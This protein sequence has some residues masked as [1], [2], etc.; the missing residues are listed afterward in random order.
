MQFFRSIFPEEPD[1]DE[2]NRAMFIILLSMMMAAGPIWM[3]SPA[4]VRAWW[5]KG[6]SRGKE[7]GKDEASTQEEGE[8]EGEDEVEA[9][10]DKST[11]VPLGPGPTVEQPTVANNYK[12]VPGT[13]VDHEGS[14]Q[15]SSLDDFGKR[16]SKYTEQDVA[17]MKASWKKCVDGRLA[18]AVAHKELISQL[19]VDLINTR[20]TERRRAAAEAGRADAADVRA[21]ATDARAAVSQAQADTAERK[22][23]EVRSQIASSAYFK[24]NPDDKKIIAQLLSERSLLQ[25]QVNAC[26]ESRRRSLLPGELEE[27][28][29]QLERAKCEASSARKS[30]LAE[31]RMNRNVLLR[32]EKAEKIIHEH[33]TSASIRCDLKQARATISEQDSVIELQRVALLQH[34]KNNVELQEGVEKAVEAIKSYKNV[35]SE[36]NRTITRQVAELTLCKEKVEESQ[37]RENERIS[38]KQQLQEKYD[39]LL[40]QFQMKE[41]LV[42]ISGKALSRC[43]QLAGKPIPTIETLDIEELKSD[44]KIKDATIHELKVWLEEARVAMCSMLHIPSGEITVP[45]ITNSRPN[46][47]AELLKQVEEK[48]GNAEAWQN[49]VFDLRKELNESNL[50][51]YRQEIESLKEYLAISQADLLEA[52]APKGALKLDNKIKQIVALRQQVEDLKTQL[53]QT[54]DAA[55]SIENASGGHHVESS[56]KVAELEAASSKAAPSIENASGGHHVELSA[57]IAELE[58]ASSNQNINIQKLQKENEEFTAKN[59]DLNDKIQQIQAVNLS[60]VTKNDELVSE[61]QQIQAVNTGLVTKNDELVSKVQH[62]QT[63]NTDLA[64]NKDLNTKLAEVA[65]LEKLLASERL[66]TQEVTRANFATE[67]ELKHLRAQLE[68][69]EGM[70]KV[71][72]ENLHGEGKAVI[73]KLQQQLNTAQQERANAVAASNSLQIRLADIQRERDAALQAILADNTNSP[74]VVENNALKQQLADLERHFRDTM[75]QGNSRMEELTKSLND[76]EQTIQGLN[77]KYAGWGTKSTGNMIPQ[78]KYEEINRENI[79]LRQENLR[80]ENWKISMQSPNAPGLTAQFK[81]EQMRRVKCEDRYNKLFPQIEVL[82]KRLQACEDSK[83]DTRPTSTTATANLSQVIRMNNALRGE[84]TRNNERYT[85]QLADLGRDRDGLLQRLSDYQRSGGD[86]ELADCTQA[87]REATTKNAE[88][89][90]WKDEHAFMVQQQDIMAEAERKIAAAQGDVERAKR[91]AMSSG[92]TGTR[93]VVRKKVEDDEEDDE[94]LKEMASPRKMSKTPRVEDEEV[95]QD[96]LGDED[97]EDSLFGSQ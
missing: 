22:L 13:F 10:S 8:G 89:R 87:L 23:R 80:L 79:R 2:V 51:E 41:T 18:D 91:D 33:G 34:S 56:T 76:K 35:F 88:L 7:G 62:I 48:C 97:D 30:L 53:K 43:R 39:D 45:A 40:G 52:R 26:I 86:T 67:N 75:N 4:L 81:D 37:T 50:Y 90:A 96:P 42:E 82:R 59:N 85:R 61:V 70:Q 16:F 29:A 49:E 28:Q 25:R 47:L 93:G 1:E 94:E 31:Q 20:R 60:L 65:S 74:S 38:S 24:S 63:V 83:N 78:Q 46:E 69:V 27:C 68:N 57:K 44:A 15:E 32:Q 17:N 5:S 73:E 19:K 21:A 58:A 71:A 77:S 11:G 3:F 95:V 92:F 6:W 12:I 14:N 66:Q 36:K 54:H 64:K 84:I 9:L 55:P 72:L